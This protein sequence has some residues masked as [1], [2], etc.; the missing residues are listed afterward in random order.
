[1]PVHPE[2]HHPHAYAGRG[3]AVGDYAMNWL[4]FCLLIFS[5]P[6]VNHPLLPD[7]VGGIE[8]LPPVL[9]LALAQICSRRGGMAV[10][11]DLLLFIVL[12]P[13]VMLWANL[14]AYLVFHDRESL[15]K[16]LLQTYRRCGAAFLAV[17]MWQILLTP[18]N[19]T[20]LLNAF[21]WSIVVGAVLFILVENLNPLGFTNRSRLSGNFLGMALDS[22]DDEAAIFGSIRVAGNAGS[23]TTY[24]FLAAVAALTMLDLARSGAVRASYAGL[25]VI[26]LF[27]C[28]LLSSAKMVILAAAVA[29]V[30][31]MA[32]NRRLWGILLAGG[33][34][35]VLVLGGAY[36]VIIE[37]I[38]SRSES[39]LDG[40]LFKFT[41]AANLIYSD[42]FRMFFGD[43]WKS[44]PVGWHSEPVEFLMAFGVLPGLVLMFVLYL[45]FPLCLLNWRAPTFALPSRTALALMFA[46]G[47]LTSLFHD[48]FLDPYTLFTA[49]LLIG[50]RTRTVVLENG[51]P[52]PLRPENVATAA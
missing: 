29:M 27:G 5:L 43:G 24:G 49:A 26:L 22:G 46:I 19:A 51:R 9:L 21:V 31:F 33:A 35:L 15:V 30:F 34:A 28:L 37:A 13:V 39:S 14:T 50:L 36:T 38:T 17:L 3:L 1:M 8:I 10:N 48:I 18:R 25:I 42:P 11:R 7:A 40:R 12:V 6:R 2:A 52:A 45:V 20:R 41:D 44:G 23:Q 47:L 4:Y 32:T 16:G